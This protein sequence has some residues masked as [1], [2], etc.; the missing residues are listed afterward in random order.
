MKINISKIITVL[1]FA[2]SAVTLNAQVQN[3]QLSQVDGAFETTHLTLTPGDYKFEIANN[4][5]DKELG[6]VL[7]PEGKYE[8]ESHIKEAYV[9]TPVANG[10]SSKTSVVSLTPGTYEYFCPLNPTPK[11]KLTVVENVKTIKLS[12]TPGFFETKKLKLSPGNYQFEIANNGID[13]EVGFVLVPAGKYDAMNHIKEA[14]VT[15]PVVNGTSSKT[16]IVSLT[17]GKY[18]YFC[19]LNPT[20]KYKLT[21]K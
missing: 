21:V 15:A 2:V 17:A 18:E 8:A 13:H 10:T 12:Q 7:V 5:V 20:E 4:G 11:Y 3:V 16:G 6:F 9:T 19:P 14:Y 1:A